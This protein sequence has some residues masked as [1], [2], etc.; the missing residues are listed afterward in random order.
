M[1][2]LLLISL[3]VGLCAGGASATMYKMDAATAEL[4]TGV[5]WSDIQTTN[6]NQVYYAGRSPGLS[7]SDKIYG[8]NLSYGAIMNYAVGFTGNLKDNEAMPDGYAS[9]SFGL[10]NNIS[11]LFPT[12]V[13]TYDSFAL[14]MINDNQ[15]QWDVRLYAVTAGSY[16]VPD[17]VTPWI[18]LPV[19]GASTSPI[20]SFGGDVDFSSSL[21]DI[22]FAIRFNKATTGLGTQTED[23]FHVSVVPVPGAF[24]LGMLGLGVAGV[25]LHRKKA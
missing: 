6:S 20:L 8:G 7:A 2:R 5:Y 19:N 23:V 3:I 10:G 12:N 18:N 14:P 25:R 15:Q 4:F 21:T 1:K 16:D 22:G 17:F 9:V 11:T 13:D 24:L